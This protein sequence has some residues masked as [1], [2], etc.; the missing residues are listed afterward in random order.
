MAR[1]AGF[2]DHGQCAA[3]G[4]QVVS[5]DIQIGKMREKGVRHGGHLVLRRQTCE[6]SCIPTAEAGIK[7]Y[8][9]AV[10]FFEFSLD[11]LVLNITFACFPTA[12]PRSCGAIVSMV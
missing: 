7:D 10:R 3:W 2:V 4:Q 11:M 9:T 8:V 12:V 6:Q 1:T 5:H